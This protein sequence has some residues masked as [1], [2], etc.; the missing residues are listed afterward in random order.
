M[1]IRRSMILGKDFVRKYRKGKNWT[2]EG[3]FQIQT[4][5]METIEAIKLYHKGPTVKIT[6]RM[7]IPSRTLVLLQGSTKL[8]KYHQHK[9]YELSPDPKIEKEYPHLV[10][11]PIL[12]QANIC[13]HLKVS[14][15]I[16]NFG[17]EDVH[18]YPD[19][20]VGILQEEK[21]RLKDIQTN[22]S[23]V[24]IC[25]VDDGEETASSVSLHMMIRLLMGRL[26]P[27]LQTFILE[28]NQN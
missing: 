7:K 10:L 18:L 8:K 23:Y 16:I 11:Y 2:V 17:D 26:L 22:T 24:S 25:E 4:F 12:H 5:S 15:C 6:K 21:L 20:K 27:P 3:Q 14:I 9:F 1:N 19:R 28:Q 13:G